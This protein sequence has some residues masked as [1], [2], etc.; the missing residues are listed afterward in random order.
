MIRYY[1]SDSN[2]SNNEEVIREEASPVLRNVDSIR[3][4]HEEVGQLEADN[5]PIVAE[6]VT[7]VAKSL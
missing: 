1:D 7:R 4:L 2:N 3:T 6:Y 5:N